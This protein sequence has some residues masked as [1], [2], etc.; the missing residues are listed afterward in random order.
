[1]IYQP[2]IPMT[3]SL[4]EQIAGLEDPAPKGEDIV[5]YYTSSYY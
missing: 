4:R 2:G 1:M 5:H 3:K